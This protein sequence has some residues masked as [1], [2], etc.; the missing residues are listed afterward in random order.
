M[1]KLIPPW[2]LHL[3][4]SSFLLLPLFFLGYASWLSTRNENVESREGETI[5]LPLAVVLQHVTS[6]NWENSAWG[7]PCSVP[8]ALLG[9][10]VIFRL[11]LQHAHL[12]IQLKIPWSNLHSL[13]NF[14]NNTITSGSTQ[15]TTR[16]YSSGSTNVYIII[17]SCA[18]A[19]AN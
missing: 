16:F 3:T 19:Q 10:Q 17:F 7:K 5:S 1:L 9:A 2:N 6:S 18:I 15:I 11:A 12:G 8:V 4:L 13:Y 14:Q